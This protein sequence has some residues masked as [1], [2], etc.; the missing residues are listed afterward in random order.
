MNIND[1]IL[2]IGESLTPIINRPGPIIDTDKLEGIIIIGGSIIIYWIYNS[3]KSK[4][5]LQVKKDQKYTLN[6]KGYI[7][8]H[9][10]FYLASTLNPNDIIIAV[11]KCIIICEEDPSGFVIRLLFGKEKRILFNNIISIIE[12]DWTQSGDFLVSKYS[13]GVYAKY[14][15]YLCCPLNDAIEKSDDDIWGFWVYIRIDTSNLELAGRQIK[16]LAGGK[17]P[18]FIPSRFGYKIFIPIQTSGDIKF[19]FDSILTRELPDDVTIQDLISRY[20]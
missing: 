14:K 17:E 12:N 15:G 4:S 5:I 3:L 6:L 20:S 18:K 7:H 1:I 2:L 9:K 10:C 11:V 8:K 13:D 19:D 16:L